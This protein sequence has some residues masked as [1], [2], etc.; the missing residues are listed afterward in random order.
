MNYPPNKENY[1]D[2][3]P[4]Y[5]RWLGEIK[6]GF[7]VI[8]EEL[9]LVKPPPIKQNSMVLTTEG[10]DRV[11]L[12]FSVED[13]DDKG[14]KKL[15]IYSIVYDITDKYGEEENPRLEI[16]P[17]PNPDIPRKDSESII[18]YL[19]NNNLVDEKNM[20]A[21][22]ITAE[23]IKYMRLNAQD[24]AKTADVYL[25]RLEF[26]A[27][28]G[29]KYSIRFTDHKG[30]LHV[31]QYEDQPKEITIN[32]RTITGWTYT[33]SVDSGKEFNVFISQTV[34]NNDIP[35][36]CLGTREAL[37]EAFLS[38]LNGLILID[39]NDNVWLEASVP[40]QEVV[41]RLHRNSKYWNTF[42][43]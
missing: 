37:G 8:G 30:K 3:I 1:I 43:F 12:E 31:C 18:D 20:Q 36:V 27:R 23:A 24:V 10:Q 5:G 35:H 2:G 25:N 17:P 11:K 32:N 38:D 42:N 15:V 33:V 6:A 40:N 22:F 26:F 41:Q 7:R 29:V 39:D 14:N 21:E 9:A 34:E 19:I 16:K 13:F 4:D 28:I